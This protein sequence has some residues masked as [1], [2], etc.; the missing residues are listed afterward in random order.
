[1]DDL[2]LDDLA[3][4]GLPGREPDR[5]AGIA[6]FAGG[7]FLKEAAATRAFAFLAGTP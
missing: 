2:A 7:C 5:S 1:L 3:L 4:D 6:C